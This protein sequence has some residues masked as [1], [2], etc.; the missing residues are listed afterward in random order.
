[1]NACGQR[2][3]LRREELGL[4]QADLIGRL[5]DVTRAE[6]NGDRRDVYRI[7]RGTRKIADVEL[8]ALAVALEISPMWLLVGDGD[9]FAESG[10]QRPLST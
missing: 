10:F 1:M 4:S 8:I 5:A 2:V 3:K 6:W 7:E 9:E